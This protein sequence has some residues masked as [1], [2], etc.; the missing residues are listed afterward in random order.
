[1]R[2]SSAMSDEPRTRTITWT[3]PADTRWRLAA[4]PGLAV[5]RRVIAGEL[6]NSPMAQLLG[7]RVADAGE[8]LA[9]VVATPAEYHYNPAG[10]VHGG[11]AATLLDTAMGCAAY[12]TMP[13][14]ETYTTVELKVNLL[15][16]MTAATGE[17]RATGRVLHRGRRTV[18]AEGR[19]ED[20]AGRLV[21]HATTTCLVYD[22]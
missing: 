16:P 4:E 6:P 12:T 14:H 13:A 2:Y 1:M 8:G 18:M 7:M 15:R 9:V 21:A 22:A 19:I 11:F 17:V 3:D 20:A 5:L 10:V